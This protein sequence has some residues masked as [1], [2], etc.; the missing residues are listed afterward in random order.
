LVKDEASKIG[1][2]YDGITVKE[3]VQI[4]IRFE[5]TGNTLIEDQ[6]IRFRFPEQA[7]ILDVDLDP[8]PEQELGVIE[9][10]EPALGAMERRYK[11]GHLEAAQ[12][13]R[14][15]IASDGGA[16][17]GWSDIHPFNEEGG[18]LFLRRDVARQKEDEDEVGPFI[19]G[20]VLLML[21]L[22]LGLA[23]PN[24]FSIVTLVLGV[25]LCFMISSKAPK[26]LRVL[27]RLLSSSDVPQI[28]LAGPQGVQIGDGNRQDNSYQPSDLGQEAE[29]GAATSAPE[30]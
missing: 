4:Y 24:I 17:P 11:V 14:F 26:V 28:Y 8:K 22:L 6:Y 10:L 13:V 21:L 3:L 19:Q 16:W 15:R 1:V 30:D 18:V 9:I 7:R 27:K 23:V 5:N 20:A 2:S 29:D 25:P 12:S